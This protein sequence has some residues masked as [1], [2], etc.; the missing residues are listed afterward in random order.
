MGYGVSDVGQRR[1]KT[2]LAAKKNKRRSSVAAWEGDDGTGHIGN[3]QTR[4][5]LERMKK[6]LEKLEAPREDLPEAKFTALQDAPKIRRR[7]SLAM[8]QAD[9]EVAAAQ[10]ELKKLQEAARARERGEQEQASAAAKAS[11][12]ERRQTASTSTLLAQEAGSPARKV[13]G[14]EL[15]ESL[16]AL[17]AEEEAKEQARKPKPRQRRKAKRVVMTPAEA[18]AAQEARVKAQEA[19][20]AAK[21]KAAAESGAAFFAF[22]HKPKEAV[23]PEEEAAPKE[24]PSYGAAGDVAAAPR[25]VH[26]RSLAG[27]DKG[28]STSLQPLQG[29]ASGQMAIAAVGAVAVGERAKDERRSARTA[30]DDSVFTRAATAA[31]A[32]RACSN[33]GKLLASGSED[34][35]ARVWDAT[36]GDLVRVLEGH[37]KR[38][39]FQQRGGFGALVS[40]V[41]F[42]PDGASLA[43]G[44]RDN[45]VR[46][47]D[48]A[49]GKI[50]LQ[51][52]GHTAYVSSVE[53]NVD[54][55]RLVS[56]SYDETAVVWNAVTGKKRMA[57][58]DKKSGHRKTNDIVHYVHHASHDRRGDRVVCASRDGLARIWDGHW[59]GG[60][61]ST[62]RLLLTLR[63]HEAAVLCAKFFV[64]GRRVA[65]ASQDKSART[66][67]A[68][69]GDQLAVLLGHTH[70]ITAVACLADGRLV[71][72]AKD[73]TIRVWE[74]KWNV[75]N[76]DH[77]VLEGH[78]D[79]VM[80]V[81]LAQNDGLLVSASFDRTLKYIFES[82]TAC[83]RASAKDGSTFCFAFMAA[84]MTAWCARSAST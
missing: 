2:Q 52:K 15:R 20:T 10:A 68:K 38:T 11:F 32:S 31:S 64:D 21:I 78:A 82:S 36:T 6:D 44:C 25:S 42:S 39:G 70:H 48:L 43:T 61:G 76:Y 27:Q 40:A 83:S 66:W 8:W 28:D 80:A 54:G 69:T 41:A 84:V 50:Q 59:D 65:T 22:D 62:G 17:V 9:P 33:D 7:Q 35:T 72:G 79:R 19:E 18:K 34:G 3:R 67:D 23:V 26:A 47:F 29:A 55:G 51:L 74:D 60:G 73:Y 37:G 58:L 77:R 63:G 46:V 53:F 30:R 56:G 57:L 24:E 13:A 75:H 12:R 81:A 1:R 45:L 14:R 16:A 71:T 4:F 49:T 5:M